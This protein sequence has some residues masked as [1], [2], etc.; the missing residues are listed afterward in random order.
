MPK[1][2]LSIAN[3]RRSCNFHHDLLLCCTFEIPIVKTVLEDATIYFIVMALC[4]L[5]LA[6]TVI[7]AKV[8]VLTFPRM[9]AGLIQ[10]TRPPSNSCLQREF[11]FH[12]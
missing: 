10:T 8:V 3:R 11:Y 2:K 5:V 4:H 6:L 1:A 9:C 7:F 12:L